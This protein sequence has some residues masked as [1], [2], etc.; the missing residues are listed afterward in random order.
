MWR[1]HARAR[2]AFGTGAQTPI[3]TAANAGLAPVRAN[4]QPT[5]DSSSSSGER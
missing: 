5:F 3:A 1:F 2:Q 4:A